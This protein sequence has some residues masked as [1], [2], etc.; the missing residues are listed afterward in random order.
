MTVLFA[1]AGSLHYLCYWLPDPNYNSL[2]MTFIALSWAVFFKLV[3][4]CRK[5]E[6]A[7]DR[8]AAVWAF[9]IGA[10]IVAGGLIKITSAALMGLTMIAVYFWLD[11]PNLSV[12]RL[13]G[14]AA[15]AILGVA[16]S[17]CILTLV[18]FNPVRVYQTMSSGYET[19][20]LLTPPSLGISAS[21][22]SYQ[23]EIRS[24]PIFGTYI[25]IAAI[26]ISI[27]LFSAKI[28]T[29]AMSVLL[30][31]VAGAGFVIAIFSP[32]AFQITPQFINGVF[33]IATIL[34]VVTVPLMLA[35]VRGK[36]IVILLLMLMSM[37]IYTYGTGNRWS[38]HFAPAVGL[39]WVAIG[40]AL[41]TLPLHARLVATMPV[42][43][44]LALSMFAAAA[45]AYQEPYRLGSPMA[46]ITDSVS[47][48]PYHD[49]MRVPRDLVPFYERLATVR[50]QVASLTR[51]PMLLDMTGRAPIVTYLIG[52][53]VP[54]ASW[55]LGGYPG[56]IPA[57]QMIAK[58]IPKD[59]LKRAWILQS[60]DYDGRF[61][62]DLL[63]EYG[64]NFPDGYSE[65][66][67]VPLP[68]INS[69]AKLYAP[70][71]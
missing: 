51:R 39:V 18:D 47:I 52:A 55:L 68:Y 13:C 70:K 33:W 8:D 10:L 54:V 15:M 36:V 29:P 59:E 48:G 22:D 63:K 5:T 12:R 35:S 16:A 20:K 64:L 53:K 7:F 27:A 49:T 57:F 67:E 61:P 41:A 42:T 45:M 65:I 26:F 38:G 6:G 71:L 21:L 62:N 1:L 37:V 30:S 28:S 58:H 32:G 60:D 46:E 17:L 66:V 2:N 44:L 24:L 3:I 69:T 23:L 50:P 4:A 34:A 31:I 11:R 25:L 56:S 43:V 19:F 9:A 40:A 14:F